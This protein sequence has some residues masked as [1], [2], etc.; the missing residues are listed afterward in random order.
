MVESTSHFVQVFSIP[1][2][3]PAFSSFNELYRIAPGKTKP[4]QN[5]SFTAIDKP[6]SVQDSSLTAIDKPQVGQDSS[7]TAI[8]KPQSVQD[9]SLTAIDKPQAW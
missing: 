9:S 1:A 5:P 8:D 4:W 3:L 2:E 6:Q 7:L